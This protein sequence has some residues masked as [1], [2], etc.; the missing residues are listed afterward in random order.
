M[1]HSALH[2]LPPAVL[3]WLGD[4]DLPD[5]PRADC[6]ACPMACSAEALPQHPRRFLDEARCCTYHPALPA[7]MVGQILEAGGQGEALI[8]ARMADR[9]GVSAAGIRASST[10]VQRRI[11]LGDDGFGRSAEVRCPYWVG[12]ELAC[13]IWNHRDAVC[14]SWFCKTEDGP[15]SV[16]LWMRLKSLLRTLED[17]LRH[18]C[19]ARGTPPPDD[20][21]T[22]VLLDWYRQ[23]AGFIAELTVADLDDEEGVLTEV[24]DTLAGL[25]G[26]L[27]QP[28]PAVLGASIRDMRPV[29]GGME[30]QGYSRWDPVVVPRGIFRVLG[31]L[32]GELGWRE[33]LALANGELEEP[34]E[35]ALIEE[36]YRRGALREIGGAEDLEVGGRVSVSQ[37]E[38]ARPAWLDEVR[39][40]VDG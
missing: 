34:L 33:A 40:L 10:H 30:M 9:D 24:R 15:R 19:D 38:E 21:P 6:G 27:N 11:A 5:E 14:R 31:R 8:V 37:G 18:L 36:M 2:N 16:A 35:E 26:A 13:G 4:L 17:H 25:R 39:G 22:A 1:A 7:W 29:E 23:C 28:L 3:K 12:G 32:T 20:A